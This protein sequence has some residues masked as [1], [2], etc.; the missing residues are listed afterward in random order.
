MGEKGKESIRL[1]LQRGHE[2]GVIETAPPV[3]FVDD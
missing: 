1:F 3:E 2:A